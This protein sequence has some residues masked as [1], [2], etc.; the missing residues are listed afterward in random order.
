MP[1]ASI[2]QN[3]SLSQIKMAI[4]D[5]SNLETT[6]KKWLSIMAKDCNRFCRIMVGPRTLSKFEI[7]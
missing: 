6:T 7:T 1:F 5:V 4:D 2:S 3:S